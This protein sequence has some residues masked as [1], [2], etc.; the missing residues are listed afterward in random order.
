MNMIFRKALLRFDIVT[1]LQTY[2]S[3]R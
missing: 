3:I 2:L 1:T